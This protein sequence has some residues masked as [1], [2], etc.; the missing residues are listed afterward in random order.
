MK[1]AL[2][3]HFLIKKDGASVDHLTDKLVRGTSTNELATPRLR[4][5]RVREGEAAPPGR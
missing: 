2:A 5:R 4:A 1:A 3:Q